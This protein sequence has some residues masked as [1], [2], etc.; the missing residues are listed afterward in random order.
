[1][2]QR[3][4]DLQSESLRLTRLVARGDPIR[5]QEQR[6]YCYI[7]W[8]KIGAN[9]VFSIANILENVISLGQM[10]G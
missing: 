8:R 3:C 1:M 2:V 9:N 7:H 4:D 6:M 10:I 5:Q